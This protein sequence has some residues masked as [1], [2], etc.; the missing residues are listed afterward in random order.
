MFTD[1]LTLC[2]AEFKD[3]QKELKSEFLDTPG[4]MGKG[5]TAFIDA[6]CVSNLPLMTLLK[7]HGANVDARTASGKNAYF[8]VAANL[9]FPSICFLDEIGVPINATDHHGYTPLHM[10]TN[11]ENNGDIVLNLI[12]HDAEPDVSTSVGA[13]S[14]AHFAAQLQDKG[15][16]TYLALEGADLEVTDRKGTTTVHYAVRMGSVK[17]LEFLYQSGVSLNSQDTHGFTP[18]H[19]AT[20]ADDDETM[21]KK[22]LELRANPEISDKVGRRPIHIACAGPPESPRYLAMI[23]ELHRRGADVNSKNSEGFTP[24]QIAYRNRNS[25]VVRY[26]CEEAGASLDGLKDANPMPDH[27]MAMDTDFP[28]DIFELFQFLRSSHRKSNKP[29]RTL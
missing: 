21:L 8:D 28:L 25:D 29:R 3:D 16:L 14:P 20:L 22:L 7:E 2:L 15:C 17:C 10:A 1:T 11:F 12:R 18:L 26:L 9:A 23:R 5:K 13:V 19:Y 6:A 24:V 4:I 27:P